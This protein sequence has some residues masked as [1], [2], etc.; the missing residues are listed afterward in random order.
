MASD[1][2]AFGTLINIAGKQRMLSHRFALL[3]TMMTACDDSSRPPLQEMLRDT[4][5]E[6]EK[7]HA[8]ICHGDE[9]MGIPPATSPAL[10][11]LI[12]SGATVME[13][14]ERFFELAGGI[15]GQLEAGDS[16]TT[17]AL[18][19][20]TLFVA[21][22]LLASLN[23]LIATITGDL[24]LA[25]REKEDRLDEGRALMHNTLRRINKSGATIRMISFNASIEAARFGESGR[26]F[27]VIA[28]EI[29]GLSIETQTTANE[30]QQQ[31]TELFG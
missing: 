14:V 11:E 19:E 13:P 28:K 20:F 31:L 24:Q 10:G 29:Q 4:L 23:S 16:P 5:V 3:A 25:S 1:D 6:L 17:E 22:P 12:A 30:M 7:N 2:S 18:I 21:G 8:C 15:A 26:A 9:S 27:A